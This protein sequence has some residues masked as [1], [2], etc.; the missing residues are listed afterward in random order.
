MGEKIVPVQNIWKEKFQLASLAFCPVLLSLESP[1][2]VGWLLQQNISPKSTLGMFIKV[3][4]IYIYLFIYFKGLVCCVSW[5]DRGLATSSLE[6]PWWLRSKDS[7]CKACSTRVWSL[8]W[9]DPLE[10]E[11]ATP[12][13]ILAGKSHGQKSLAGYKPWGCKKLGQDLATKQL[14]PLLSSAV[15]IFDSEGC[16]RVCMS[17]I[18]NDNYC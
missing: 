5:K 17:V 1:I 7:A 15:I 6:L 11:M 18:S 16:Q 10:K 2:E 9:E 4:N 3:F 13:S 14:Q 12:S 8:S